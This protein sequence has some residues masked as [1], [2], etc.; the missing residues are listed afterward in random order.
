MNFPKTMAVLS[1]SALC[2]SAATAAHA[3]PQAAAP[4]ALTVSQ[5]A[6]ATIPAAKAKPVKMTTAN[7]HLRAG[8]NTRSKSLL[9]VPKS[10][11]VTILKVS[12]KW[13]QV[14]HKKKTGWVSGKFLK[15]PPKAKAKHSA[16]KPKAAKA[17]SYRY[18][19]GYTA[20]RASASTKSK[21]TYTVHRRTKMEYLAKSGSWLKVRAAG[22][23]GYVPSSQM[24]TK[25]P[26][27]VYRWSTKAQNGLVSTNAKSK[28]LSKI[29]K[30]TK[31]EWLRT[32]GAWQTVRSS[33]GPVWVR[34]SG[35]ATK[36]P[37][38]AAPKKKAPAKPA[39]KPKPTS[40]GNV[41]PTTSIK[42]KPQ[43]V[44]HR[45]TTAAVNVRTGGSVN[46]PSLG[47]IPAGTKVTHRGSV[48]GWAQVVTTRGTGWINENYLSRTAFTPPAAPKPAS[49]RWTTGNVN[50]RT[51][52]GVNHPSMGVIPAGTKLTL[53]GSVKDWSQVRHGTRTG[54]VS[55]T[56][57]SSKAVA[58]LQPDTIAVNA[59]VAKHFGANVYGY[60]GVRAGS[61]GH[62]AGKA[63]DLMIRNYKTPK[64]I[65][66]GN[67]VAQF[68]L[69][70]RTKLGISYLIWDDMIWLNQT[71]GWQ[72]YSKGGYGK[73]FTGNWNDTTLHHD[74]VH[75]E[76]YGNSGTGGKL[77]LRAKTGK[78][79]PSGVLLNLAK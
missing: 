42:P 33:K 73:Q 36:A 47:A 53:L 4:Q 31:V 75:A 60:G 28:T 22:K 16:P 66:D 56:Y 2:L 26:G 11:R 71:S 18:T 10:T 58:T 24:A 32:T 15:N 17:K 29:G 30:G 70:N 9:V 5:L 14:K 44:S 46:H 63:T 19:R 39:P 38:K 74:H 59:A 69:D 50:F 23:T 61:V 35:L 41:A 34:S 77:T 27:A 12:G 1:I 25:N 64:G 68:L 7:L 57:L 37:N 6:A 48:N 78:L 62:S 8:K 55:S 3:A 45:W 21:T 20:V 13:H 79:V 52:G 65:A 67:D 51:G 76:V 54:W 40:P 72:E 49:D 43:A